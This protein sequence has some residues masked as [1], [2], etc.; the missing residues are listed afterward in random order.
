V[1]EAGHLSV[2]SSL[3]SATRTA[4]VSIAG[5]LDLN[6]V[7][8]LTAEL[9]RWTAQDVDTVL[10]DAAGVTFLDSSGLSALLAGR[11]SVRASGAQL[12]V[13]ATSTAV[14]RVLDMTGTRSILEG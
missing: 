8:S 13:V 14:A 4:R 12:K 10:V 5:E 2:E 11:E 1:D 6:G 3:D 7:D 9:N